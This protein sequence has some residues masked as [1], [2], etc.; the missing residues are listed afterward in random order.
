[1]IFTVSSWVYIVDR[2][3][4][5][6]STSYRLVTLYDSNGVLVVEL[7]TAVNRSTLNPKLTVYLSAA[8]A[9]GTNTDD[10]KTQINSDSIEFNK[11]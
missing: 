7:D 4:V 3:D 10:I 1:M 8:G 5:N 6:D 2:D 11:W 9:D